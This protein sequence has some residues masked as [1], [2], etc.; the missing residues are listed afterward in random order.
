MKVRRGVWAL[1]AA[2]VPSS[3]LAPGA[4]GAVAVSVSCGDT[5]TID[6]KLAND[7]TDCPGHGIVIGA[8][9]ITLDLNG[10]TV[11]G[12]GNGAGFGVDNRAGHDRV[13]IRGGSIREFLEG[14]MIVGARENRLRDLSTSHNRHGGIGVAESADVQIERNSSAA[15]ATGIFVVASRHVRVERNRVSDNEFAAIP[16]FE[17]EHVRAAENSVSNNEEGILL[18]DG[19]NNNMIEG[20]FISGNLHA[21]ILVE[22]DDNAV[23]RNRVLRSGDGIPVVGSR[24]T[25]TDN[26]VVDAVGCPDGCG[27]GIFLLGGKDN[28]VARNVVYRAARGIAVAALEPDT[29]TVDTV[30]RD[31]RVINVTEDGF[32]VAIEGDGG[33]ISGTLIERNVAIDSGDDGFDIRSTATTLTSNLAVRNGDLGIEA[34]PG[35]TDGGGNR[36]TANGNPLQCTGVACS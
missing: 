3:A 27:F 36:A 5:I 13:T 31:N 25:V 6:T 35:V 18:L 20:N 19:S 14:V 22:G 9:D 26:R 23:S 17:S 16:I 28:L 11:D 34:L 21:G 15:N 10:H 29:P 30:V 1:L 33:I 4:Y 12:N 8:D 32:L 7:L 2:A 24:N